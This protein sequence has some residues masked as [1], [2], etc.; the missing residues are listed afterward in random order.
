MH[1]PSCYFDQEYVRLSPYHEWVQVEGDR[2]RQ[3][4]DCR[5][6]SWWVGVR[7]ESYVGILCTEPFTID[8]SSSVD[9]TLQV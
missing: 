3:G 4:G 1:W 7:N 6:Y 9:E 2:L 5:A 8:R